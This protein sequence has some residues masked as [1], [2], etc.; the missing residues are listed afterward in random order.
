MA[1]QVLG[2]EEVDLLLKSLGKEEEV[3]EKS[4]GYEK[5]DID[6]LEHISLGTIAGLE[7]ILEK[8]S[9]LSRAKLSNLVVAINNVY[10]AE[11]SLIRFEDLLSKLPVPSCINMFN[12]TGLKGTH[13]LILDPRMIY[14]I[15]SVI[16]GGSAKPYK[17]EGKEFTRLE[18]KI[19]KKV[20]DLLLSAFQESW[21]SILSGEVMYLETEVN[22]ALIAPMN[23]KK[24]MF[25]QAHINIEIDGIEYPIF[26]ALQNSS[27]EP[28]VDRLRNVSEVAEYVDYDKILKE[29]LK[30]IK[31]KLSATIDGGIFSV[32]DILDWEVGDQ[33]ILK[34]PANKP[35][36]VNVEGILKMY[37]VLGRSKSKKAVKILKMLENKESS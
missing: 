7:I 31:V 12:I 27:L 8:W 18:L 26:L 30:D 25:I 37:G 24:E 10:K 4:L 2:Q 32:K 23:S 1:E 22:P 17:I 3:E 19:I 35:I 21:S 6:D 28:V 20:V 13:F 11:T 15:V 16:F 33:I 36:K 14:S 34:A 29:L 5:F 9:R